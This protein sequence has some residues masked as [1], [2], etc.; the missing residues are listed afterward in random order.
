MFN[1]ISAHTRRYHHYGGLA[2]M[3]DGTQV[4]VVAGGMGAYDYAKETEI[5][6]LGRDE[7]HWHPG[8]QLPR[9]FGEGGGPSIPYQG[10]FL[11]AS[12][13]GSSNELYWF[14]PVAFE[15]VFKGKSP[16]NG[17]YFTGALFPETYIECI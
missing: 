9:V 11:A 12:S 10:S 4:I 3:D 16:D 17:Y 2:T 5:L 15:F 7:T 13:P 1:S 6:F 8:P 14:D